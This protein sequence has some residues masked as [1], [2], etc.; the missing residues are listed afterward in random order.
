[1]EL[2]GN[3]RKAMLPLVLL[4]RPLF[5]AQSPGLNIL[6]HGV[7]T[8]MG[9]TATTVFPDSLS[10]CQCICIC[11]SIIYIYILHILKINTQSFPRS[12]RL[13]SI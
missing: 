9:L 7:E 11:I 4:Q 1:M 2:G 6:S 5:T 8:T 13:P 3:P 12:G 10:G